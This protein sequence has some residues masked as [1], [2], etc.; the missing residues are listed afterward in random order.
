MRACLLAWNKMAASASVECHDQDSVC[1]SS[2]DEQ[3]AGD[4]EEEEVQEVMYVGPYMYEPD[5]DENPQYI[6]PER[7]DRLWRLDPARLPE[8][9][10]C[11]HC[12]TMPTAVECVCC[13]EIPQVMDKRMTGQERFHR[14]LT[15]ITDHP[16]MQAVCLCPDGLQVA[17]LT[18]KQQYKGKAFNGPQDAKYR[19]IA[20][21][22]FVRW[23]W[24]FLGKDNR[25]VLPACAVSCIRAHFPPPG[26][27]ENFVFK[28]FLVAE[29]N[30]PELH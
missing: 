21:R 27:E 13:A 14:K 12:Q 9:C 4:E 15:C 28:G 18:Y 17:W 22:Q 3:M 7:P 20:Y 8:W 30:L 5:A 11:S 2:E 26:E 16:G 24:E 19:H 10:M 1:S 6:A 29:D 23:C 25:T